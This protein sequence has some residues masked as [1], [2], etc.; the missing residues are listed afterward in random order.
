MTCWSSEKPECQTGCESQRAAFG[1]GLHSRYASPCGRSAPTHNVARTAITIARVWSNT[2]CAAARVRTGLNNGLY[3][4][5]CLVRA[6]LLQM[7]YSRSARASA[8]GGFCASARHPRRAL[9]R[10]CARCGCVPSQGPL[11]IHNVDNEAA[12]I[13]G[14]ARPKAEALQ[15]LLMGHVVA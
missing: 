2:L 10:R 8:T 15:S 7:P 12:S 3:S 14:S 11:L 5:T 6:F 4:A 13:H 9:K 1:G